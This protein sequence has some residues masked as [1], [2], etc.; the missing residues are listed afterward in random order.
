MWPFDDPAKLELERKRLQKE[1]RLQ[2]LQ[3]WKSPDT[4][5]GR[6]STLGDRIA[7]TYF[8]VAYVL[9]LGALLYFVWKKRQ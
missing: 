4:S 3:F 8:P 7:S 5:A 1:Q 9:A 2:R 6:Q